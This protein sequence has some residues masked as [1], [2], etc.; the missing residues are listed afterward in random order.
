MSDENKGKEQDSQTPGGEEKDPNT[1][2][3]GSGHEGEGMKLETA[4]QAELVEYAK[5]LRKENSTYRRRAKETQDQLATLKTE[6]EDQA[7]R[8]K[9]LED[10]QKT[11]EQKEQERVQKLE[12]AAGRVPSLERYHA[13]VEAELKGEMKKIEAMKAEQKKPFMD[14][15]SSFAEDDLLGRL[16]IIRVVQMAAGI[17]QEMPEG[18]EQNPSKPGGGVSES[19]LREKLGWSSTGLHEAGLAGL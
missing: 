17:R 11:V 9:A 12:E 13:H 15:L 4:T 7:S 16:N 6:H 18:D 1:G 2:E 19:T 14:A 8:L 3:G 10:G 5:K